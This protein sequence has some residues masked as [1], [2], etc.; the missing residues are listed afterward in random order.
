METPI[1]LNIH[2]ELHTQNSCRKRWGQRD[3]IS[4]LYSELSSSS[5]IILLLFFDSVGWV[6]RHSQNHCG[7]FVD[8]SFLNELIF[9]FA[10]MPQWKVKKTSE[11]ISL[12]CCEGTR[13]GCDGYVLQNNC[14][15]ALDDTQAFHLL[16]GTKCFTVLMFSPSLPTAGQVS[17]VHCSYLFSLVRRTCVWGVSP[18]EFIISPASTISAS[19]REWE[20]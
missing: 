6:V 20:G 5:Q 10:I 14:L 9:I 2:W 4:R 16:F 19:V 7:G 1:N 18:S 3:A 11:R 15:W 17:L 8:F 13:E 12:R